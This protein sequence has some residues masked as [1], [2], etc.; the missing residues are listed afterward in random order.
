V[1]QVTSEWAREVSVDAWLA[2]SE[3]G[4]VT[5]VPPSVLGVE[6]LRLEGGRWYMLDAGLGGR[7]VIQQEAGGLFAEYAAFGSGVPIVLATRGTL[8]FSP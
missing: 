4:A 8:T 2:K 1:Y 3:S 7:F 6:R 5:R